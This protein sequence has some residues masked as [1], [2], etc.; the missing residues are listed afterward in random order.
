MRSEQSHPGSCEGVSP[1]WGHHGQFSVLREAAWGHTSI[2]SPRPVLLIER[3]REELGKC[4]DF[5]LIFSCERHPA[6]RTVIK[7]KET[8]M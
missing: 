6:A 2:F 8:E 4:N 7:D 3:E 1:V 5:K